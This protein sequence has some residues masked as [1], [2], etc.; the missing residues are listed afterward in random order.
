[1]KTLTYDRL[2]QTIYT[3]KLPNGL[4]LRVI[5]RPG[6]AKKYAFFAADYG[7]IDTA[8]TLDGRQMR[9]ADGVAHYLEHKMFD[10]A[11][12]NAMEKLSMTGASPNAFTSYNITAYYFECTESFQENL[13]T[14]LSFVSVPY[15]TEESV[16]K[17]QGI[18]GQEIK[19]YE[20]NPSSR[21]G[22][23]LFRAMYQHHPLRVPIAGTVE[24]IADI[25][26]Q[27]LYDCHKAFYDP[28]NMMLC[29]VGDV[30]PEQ[31]RAI[32]LE[33]LPKEPGG[34]SARDYGPLEPEQPAQSYISQEMEVSMPMFAVGFKCPQVPK[35]PER[36]RQELI[37]DLVAEVLC[38]E[39][40]PLYLRLYE[41][42][43]ID[44]GFSVGY[45]MVKGMPNISASGDSDDPR[46]VL[47]AILEEG[48]RI[49]QE[50]VDEGL[51]QRLK[52]SSLG[53]RIR[54]LDSFDGMC[55]RMAMSGFDG[56]DYFTFPELYDSITAETVREMIA[57][58]VREDQAVLSVILPK[59][60]NNEE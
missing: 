49:A 37:G 8:F 47:S 20:D 15:F 52:R 7:S 10:T 31:V 27:M 26:A 53:R 2:E 40:S 33:V 41:Q 54:G 43:L 45:E 3:D 16:E 19:M 11:E 60:H 38:G 56:Y 13:K 23:N 34:V 22:E 17:E 12:G 39:S 42:G 57:A 4:E 30:D 29:V 50:G 6:F 21:L 46:A 9:S 59:N 18:I 28:S 25:S 55:Y 1:M 48:R 32:A 36:L 35:G 58:R 44:S 14:L 51:F 24:S 5:R